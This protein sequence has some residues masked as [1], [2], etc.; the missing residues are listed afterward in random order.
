[1]SAPRTGADND[2]WFH[3][4]A[5]GEPWAVEI[6][7]AVDGWQHTSLR[8]TALA[9]GGEVHH[10]LGGEEVVVVPLVGAV[11]VVV[12]GQTLGLRGRTSVF[13]GPSDVA[14]VPAGRS[15]L[16]R[17]G[18]EGARVAV[19]G[20]QVADPTGGGRTPRVVTADETP[21]ELRGAGSCSREVRG[22][23]MPD[24][25]PEAEQ[26]LVCEVVTP[27]AGW[28]SYPPHKHDSDR[29][30]EESVLEE[31]YYFETQVVGDADAGRAPVTRGT[32]RGDGLDPVGYQQV[33]GTDE[34][35]IDVLVEVSTGDV[36]LVPHGWHG[37]AMAAPDADLYYLN[38]MAGPG[39]ER[40]WL[41]CDDPAH[42]QV[43]E[44][45]TGQRVDPRLPMGATR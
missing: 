32:E 16:L 42:G 41:I 26:I 19:C 8:V 35:A 38:V 20:A 44:S 13:A 24:T 27:A 25:L 33:Y 23:G 10:D 22:H 29:P 31:I 21:V 43:R 9:A 45:W 4:F 6:T 39:A 40:A 28:S 34:R 37:P 15:L 5:A 2:R 3:P 36:V 30:G 17:A 18:A 1:M 14:Y 7:D 12:D 11:D